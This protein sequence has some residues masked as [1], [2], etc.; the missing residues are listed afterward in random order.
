M[1]HEVLKV[2]R[3]LI[4]AHNVV[5]VITRNTI[6]CGLYEYTTIDTVMKYLGYFYEMIVVS[7]N[8]D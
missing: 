1:T 4:N 8:I 3:D 7:Q 6:Y 5:Y 2:T